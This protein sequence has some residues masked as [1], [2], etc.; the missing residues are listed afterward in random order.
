MNT[1][2]ELLPNAVSFRVVTTIDV[3]TDEQI[4]TGFTGRVRLS[5]GGRM[6]SIAWYDRGVLE[7]PSLRTPAYV[8]VR[9]DGR[10]KQ[11][12]HYRL[13]RLHDPEPGRP[14]VR[15]YFANGSLRYEEHY[16]YGRRHDSNGTPA[17]VKWREDGSVRGVRRYF[18][19]HRVDGPAPGLRRSASSYA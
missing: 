1:L 10:I 2:V 16:R 14:A 11:E 5:V 13:G 4:P 15:G 6:E 3:E 17:I 18:E 8:R 9:R 19:G 7:D 12:R